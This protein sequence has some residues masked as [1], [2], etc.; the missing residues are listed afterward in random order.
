MWVIFSHKAGFTNDSVFKHDL[1]S[2]PDRVVRIFFLIFHKYFVLIAL[3]RLCTQD[4]EGVCSGVIKCQ[5]ING[6]EM[7]C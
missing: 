4:K 3:K 1:D 5:P 7:R 2:D 6:E